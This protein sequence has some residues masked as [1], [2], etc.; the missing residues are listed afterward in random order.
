MLASDQSRFIGD[1]YSRP[2]NGLGDL[3]LRDV[4]QVLVEEVEDGV[5]AS[6]KGGRGHARDMDFRQLATYRHV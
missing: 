4:P 2:M 3:R 6:Q 1:R 5:V